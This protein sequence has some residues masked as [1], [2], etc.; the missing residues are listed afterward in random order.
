VIPFN[1]PETGL[2]DFRPSS[3]A[4]H[5]HGGQPGFLTCFAGW[6]LLMVLVG[7]LI[8]LAILP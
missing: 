8:G 6:S 1:H 2:R 7:F 4:D 5:S 3:P